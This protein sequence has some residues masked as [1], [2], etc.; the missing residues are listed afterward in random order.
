MKISINAHSSS[1]I[2][3]EKV[4]YFDPFMVTEESHYAD[5]I[6]V[7]HEHHDHFS[8]EDIK[9]TAKNDTIYVFPASMKA[10][11]E[12]FMQDKNRLI[13]LEPGE[14][15]DILGIPTEAV[16]AYNVGK[17]MHPRENDWLSY[18]VTVEGKRIYVCGD[19]D[20]S[21][22]ALSV[23]CDTVLVPCGGTYTMN[24][25]EAAE[26]VNKL[27]PKT[28]I[29]MHYG[30]LVGKKGDGEEFLSKVDDGIDVML[31]IQP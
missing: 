17:P 1:C 19:M 24:A 12:E 27:R 7:S 15:R 29:P 8:P 28:A 20:S 5:I 9:K 30:S 11:A 6:F 4:L 31:L 2:R 14:K 13:L 22:E 23:S 16:R 10:E 25:A 26:F 3:G 21:E 18:V